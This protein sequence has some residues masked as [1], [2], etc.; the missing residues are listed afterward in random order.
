MSFSVSEP[1]NESL[2]RAAFVYRNS[3]TTAVHLCQSH[4]SRDKPEAVFA[5]FNTLAASRSPLAAFFFTASKRAWCN[6][7][8]RGNGVSLSPIVTFG[9]RECKRCHSVVCWR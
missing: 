7:A 1:G 9:T 6:C 3:V 8:G 5:I 2:N 4:A